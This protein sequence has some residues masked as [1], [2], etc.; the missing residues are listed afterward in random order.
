MAASRS[1]IDG[2]TTFNTVGPIAHTVEDAETVFRVLLGEAGQR[3]MPEAGG[4]EGI[5]IAVSPTMGYARSVSAGIISAVAAAADVLRSLGASVVFQDPPLE[6]PIDTYNTLGWAEQAHALAPIVEKHAPEMEPGLV[7]IVEIGS[8]IRIAEYL[9]ATHKRWQIARTMER[10]HEAI[11]LLVT[12]TLPVTAFDA[13]H[14]TPDSDDVTHMND[15]LPFSS[16][17][18]LTGQPALTVPLGFNAE[19]LPFG[20]QFVGRLGSDFDV[21]KIGRAFERATAQL[22]SYRAAA[23]RWLFNV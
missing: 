3:G 7:R 1:T 13:T 6:W 20:I 2:Y 16:L 9:S 19:H 4:L 12:P 17:F 21:L 22:A 11:D 18:N 10:F 15:W 14:I 8:R 5:R 23:E